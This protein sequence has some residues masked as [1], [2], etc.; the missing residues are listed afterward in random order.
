MKTLAGSPIGVPA[1]AANDG[2][3]DLDPA[4]VDE[5]DDKIFLL[6]NPGA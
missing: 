5:T 4:G 6:E 1:A 3:G 2:D